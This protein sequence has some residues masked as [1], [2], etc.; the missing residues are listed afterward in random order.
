M[1]AT[2][3]FACNLSE[4]RQRQWG[5]DKEKGVKDG[6]G[7]GIIR[8]NVA[9]GVCGKAGVGEQGA[10]NG[11]SRWARAFLEKPRSSC[12]LGNGSWGRG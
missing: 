7:Q 3:T 1:D 2:E 12:G 9:E 10:G 5:K 11:D 8:L 6:R 4:D